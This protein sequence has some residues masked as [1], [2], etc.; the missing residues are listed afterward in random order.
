MITRNT[1][2]VY[3]AVLSHTPHTF[4]EMEM[5]D[6]RSWALETRVYPTDSPVVSLLLSR[7][8]FGF[9]WH[10]GGYS[11]TSTPES[12]DSTLNVDYGVTKRFEILPKVKLGFG[13]GGVGSS[14][15]TDYGFLI[16]AN[17]QLSFATGYR[18]HFD[19][20]FD[21]RNEFYLGASWTFGGSNSGHMPIEPV[22]DKKQK[23][24]QIQKAPVIYEEE[25]TIYFAS[26]S[27]LLSQNAEEKLEQFFHE[28]GIDNVQKVQ[29]FA[30]A[31][32]SGPLALNKKLVLER[33]KNTSAVIEAF[34]VQN[35]LIDVVAV[36]IS[37]PVADNATSKGRA[38][39]RRAEIRIT[40]EK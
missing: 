23:P 9:D 21:N 10:L 7:E 38:L 14:F 15:Y 17:S 12:A 35:Q 19:D 16:D 24:A 20:E 40:L 2:I 39:N 11:F 33:G 37:Q 6:D 3:A 13:V 26:E 22:E 1:L 32:S 4:A 25:L 31:D 28:V 29:I 27:F 36:G 30:H 8:Q 18:F 5:T 34:G